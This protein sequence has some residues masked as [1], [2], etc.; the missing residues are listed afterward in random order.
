MN[1]YALIMKLQQK[2]A[3]DKKF[4]DRFNKAVKDLNSIP[5]LQAE[6]LKIIQMN[7]ESARQNA[8]NS[9]PKKAKNTVEEILKLL[10]N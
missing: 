2:I 10:N 6:V 7:N 4:A 5:G 3:Q 1:G 8:L 9:L